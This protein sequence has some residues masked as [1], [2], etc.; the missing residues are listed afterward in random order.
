MAENKN[1]KNE[2]IK[3][4]STEQLEGEN[5]PE[6]TLNSTNEQVVVDE[7]KDMTPQDAV[8]EA[9]DVRAVPADEPVPQENQEDDVVSMSEAMESVKEI[10]I[11]DIV[12]GEILTIEDNKRAIVGLGGGLEGVIPQNELSAVPFEDVTDVLNVGDK[13]DLVVIKE[14]KDK[15]QGSYLLSKKRIDARKVW[16]DL[17]EKFDAN[18]TIEAPVTNVVKGGLVVDAGVRGFVPASLVDVDYIEDFTPF[19]GN[20]YEFKIIEIE[21]S[22]NRLILSRKAILQKDREAKKAEILEQLEA[23]QIVKGIIARLTNFG[24]FIDLGGV[25]GLVHISEIAHE[26]VEKPSDKLMVGEEI[27]V[28]VLSVDKEAERISLSIKETLPGPWEGIEEKVQKDDVLDGTVKRLTSFGAFVEVLPGVEGLV[29]IS[30]I[31]H[32][33]IAT[34]HEVLE[35]NQ[36]IKVKVLD[37]NPQEQ[38]LSLSVKALEEKE[39]DEKPSP[40][41]SPSKKQQVKSEDE[42]PESGFTFG[43]I[44]GSQL[45]ELNLDEDEEENTEE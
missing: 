6:K 38:R 35:V 3:D 44:L 24:A 7:S 9:D 26:H 39:Q 1:I 18:E 28:K 11:G 29:H 25:D 5:T 10:H 36:K 2:N 19:E 45:S 16:D 4:V 15:E 14:V 31:S 8:V 21:P 33:H 20:T 27:E 43:D 23:D 22:E 37:V 30:Q 42:E 34:P 17:Q 12:K 41:K 40:K 13:V 32:K